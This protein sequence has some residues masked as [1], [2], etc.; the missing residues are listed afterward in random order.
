MSRLIACLSLLLLAACQSVMDTDVTRFH[1][2]MP[3]VTGQTYTI[4]PEGPQIG[5]LE[6]LSYAGLAADALNRQGLIAAAPDG[7]PAQLVVLLHYGSAGSKTE[8]YSDI[9]PAF[10]GWRSWGGWGVGGSFPIY[11][12]RTSSYTVFYQMLEVA[13]FDGPQWRAGTRLPMF[14][15]RAIGQT[16]SKELNPAMPYLVEALFQ[17]F[18]GTN[19]QTVHVR[20]PLEAAK[21]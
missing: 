21:H 9:Q 10:G 19:G 13:I 2:T 20:I 6:F 15:G 14:Q 18:P 4:Q 5:S 11:E 12:D 7:P 17:T 3:P 16:G 1:T 8:V